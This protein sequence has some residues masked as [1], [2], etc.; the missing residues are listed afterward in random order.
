VTNDDVEAITFFT[1]A[2]SAH[3]GHESLLCKIIFV[4]FVVLRAF[5]ISPQSSQVT[6]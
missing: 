2:R 3:E 6:S 4:I 5:V 1:K